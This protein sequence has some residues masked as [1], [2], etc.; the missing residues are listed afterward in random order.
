MTRLGAVLGNDEALIAELI[1]ELSHR[2]IRDGTAYTFD[3][4]DQFRGSCTPAELRELVVRLKAA[5]AKWEAAGV[6]MPY[7]ENLIVLRALQADAQEWGKPPKVRA[8]AG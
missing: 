2:G 3:Q 7:W 4:I 5:Q 1:P 8:K 6:S